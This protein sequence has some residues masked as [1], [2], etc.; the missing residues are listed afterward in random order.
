M[1]DPAQVSAT[2]VRV[3]DELWQARHPRD[4]WSGHLASSPLATATAISALVLA[5]SRTGEG[6][7][8]DALP[9]VALSPQDGQLVARGLEYLVARQN[10]DGGWGDTQY[11]LSNVATTMLA[12]AAFRLAGVP[13][14]CPDVLARAQ[15][16]LD[17]QGGIA[18]IG[19]RYGR[20]KTFAVPILTNAALAGLV[21][22]REVASLPFEAAWMPQSWYRFLRLPVVSYAVPALVAMG[23]AKFHHNPP[24]NPLVRLL[25]SAARRPTLR[26]L[27]RMQPESGGFLEATPLTAFVAMSLAS[28]GLANHPAVRRGVEFLRRS[29]RSDGSW[30]IDT[31]LATWNT[32]LALNAWLPRHVDEHALFALEGKRLQEAKE[33]LAPILDYLLHCQHRKEHP[34][35]GS[36]PGGWAWTELSGGVPDADDTSGALLALGRL[37][38]GDWVPR[39]RLP[40]VDEAA[41][42][43]VGWLLDLQNRDGGWPTFCRGWGTLPFDRSACDL[44]AH[45]LRALQ[46]WKTVWKGRAERAML[47]RRIERALEKG[48]AYL[49]RTQQ[50]DG[51]WVP[52]WFGNQYH[53][54]EE[55]PVYGTARVL[56]AYAALGR[57]EAPQ[58]R[59]GLA[60]LAAHQNDDGGWGGLGLGRKHGGEQAP[61]PGAEALSTVEETAQAVEALAVLA[62]RDAKLQQCLHRGVNWLL[63]AVEQ[64]RWRQVSPIGFYF[65][66]LWYYERMYP[67][68]FTA[69]AL[70]RAAAAFCK[71]HPSQVS[72]T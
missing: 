54:R 29:A 39:D 31:N 16:Y 33:Q 57:C 43:G 7:S 18:A 9:R 72:L 34:Y 12:V 6:T 64:D 35:T 40:Q 15:H 52:L 68:T 55:N 24:W 28:C 49:N 67:I 27:E 46:R 4:R 63:E 44:T 58:A 41:R 20:D 13:G 11:S 1:I 47:C 30:P 3:R 17:R 50:K 70:S 2:A 53:P 48:L 36:P 21:S 38:Q 37:V 14:N 59:R 69:A 71:L 66:K 25:R 32:T 51:S 61:L 10:P 26:V 65:A 42:A 8:G 23:Q 62:P 56:L 5:G 22:W 19:A 45:A 60:Y